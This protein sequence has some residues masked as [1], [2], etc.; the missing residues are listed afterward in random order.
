MIASRRVARLAVRELWM[1]FRLL[2]DGTRYVRDTVLQDVGRVSTN[3]D[4]TRAYHSSASELV[5]YVSDVTS[6][7]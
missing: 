2:L 7:Q 6:E 4:C 5:S 1:T 3:L